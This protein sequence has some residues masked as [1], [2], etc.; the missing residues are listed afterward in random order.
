[1]GV[2]RLDYMGILLKCWTIF[3]VFKKRV[4]LVTGWVR[5]VSTHLTDRNHSVAVRWET[6]WNLVEQQYKVKTQQ[7]VPSVWVDILVNFHQ[8]DEFIMEVESGS[9]WLITL[10][11]LGQIKSCL[12]LF[13]IYFS[14]ASVVT[15]ELAMSLC[16]HHPAAPQQHRK[17]SHPGRM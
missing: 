14:A 9:V 8:W 11:M 17:W 4:N 15:D 2:P 3:L 1:M 6:D 7:L 13:I 5:A 10:L 12:F 16:Q